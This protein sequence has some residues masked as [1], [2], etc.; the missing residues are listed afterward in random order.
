MTAVSAMDESIHRVGLPFGGCAIVWRDSITGQITKID[1]DCNRL[2]AI[3]YTCNNTSI[4]LLTCYMPCD[5]I[6]Y[7]PADLTV[8]PPPPND[9]GW[10]HFFRIGV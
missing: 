10:V 6:G 7:E 5:N 8:H 1:S 2:C 4:L 9:R 3:M